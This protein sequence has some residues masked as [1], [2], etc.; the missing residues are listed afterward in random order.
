MLV[1][2]AAVIQDVGVM[3]AGVLEGVGEDGHMVKGAVGVD[4]PGQRSRMVDV[5]QTGSRVTGGRDCR[6]PRV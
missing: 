4:G 2:L 6:S 3:A 5:I 1:W